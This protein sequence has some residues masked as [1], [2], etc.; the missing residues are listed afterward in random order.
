VTAQTAS[1]ER[2]FDIRAALKRSREAKQAYRRG[3]NLDLR[4]AELSLRGE[5][6]AIVRGVNQ[7]SGHRKGSGS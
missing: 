3:D 5:D 2:D 1:G 7:E 4:A 6:P